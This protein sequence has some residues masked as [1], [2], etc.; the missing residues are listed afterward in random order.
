MYLDANI[1]VVSALLP[2][3]PDLLLAEISEG[4]GPDPLTT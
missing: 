3:V 2:P 1:R 4:P